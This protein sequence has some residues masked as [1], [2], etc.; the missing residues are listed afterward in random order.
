MKSIFP[1][2]GEKMSKRAHLQSMAEQIIKKGHA[3]APFHY[4]NRSYQANGPLEAG[5]EDCHQ[6]QTVLSFIN[7]GNPNTQR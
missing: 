6:E 4:E 7:E 5:E 2:T 3:S 1:D